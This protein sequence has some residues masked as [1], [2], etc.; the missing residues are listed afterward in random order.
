MQLT[1]SSPESSVAPH[2]AG[3]VFFIFNAKHP[4]PNR[5]FNA[6]V[7][8][9]MRLKFWAVSAVLFLG[10]GAGAF[11]WTLHVLWALIIVV[12][13][14]VMGIM[15]MVQPKRA[16]LRNFP[17]LGRLRYVAE[18]IRPGVRQY[19][20]ESDLDG[21]PFSRRKRSLVYSRAKSE[22]E[23]VPF[24]T[25][26]DVYETGYEWMSHSIYALDPKQ[27]EQHPR[28]LVGGKDCKQ[29]YSLSIFNVSAMSY[30]SLSANAVL[31]L[32][33]G[34]KMGNFAHNTG[35][36]G[37]SPYHLQNGGDLIWQVGTGYFGCRA[38]DGGFD[39]ERFAQTAS[40]PSIKM[41]E[42]KLSQ[43][44]K[45]GHGGIL[46]AK[47]NT[48]AIAK[49]RG[50]EPYTD[51]LSPPYHKAFNS[52]E[53]LMELLQRM[54]ELS[55]GKPVGFKLC[56]GSEREFYNIC[57]AM[58]GTGICPDFIT[59]DGGEGGTGAAP[60]EFS[61]SLGMPLRDG[62]SFAVDTLNG[63]DLRDKIRVLAAGRVS[64]G[65]DIAKA[66]ALGADAC[67]S[68]RA[69][70][71]ALGCIQALVCNTNKCPTGVATQDPELVKGLVVED[72]ASRVKNFHYKTVHA[73]VELLSA[74]G[75][76]HYKQLERRHIYRRISMK[77]VMRYDELF[78]N[79]PVGC[80]LNTDE[81]PE[82]FR[83]QMLE[84]LG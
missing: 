47:K 49:I 57:K 28:T 12:P 78:P 67:Y 84:W 6:M 33:Q 55:G 54:R 77:E 81:I 74:A 59:I 7:I 17:L 4:P 63:F 21:R 68:A 30:G 42:L 69:M 64:C 3:A 31:A 27:L 66:I 61:D 35:E 76:K 10:I 18:A 36:G 16:L 70:M 29:P 45:P 48:P 56:I 79:V 38:K 22:T 26:L 19:F 72:K 60:V 73:F 80:L 53:G 41:I 44:A 23:T 15:D 25:Q 9:H 50:V 71:M 82:V 65:F 51:V 34:A 62:L 5:P 37:V 20:I 2:G 46:P 43:G 14:F 32:N 75:M 11:F 52:P 13:L 24:G 58:I 1:Q 8:P 40:A 83:R 39:P